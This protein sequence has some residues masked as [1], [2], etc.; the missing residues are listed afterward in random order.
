MYE[1]WPFFRTVVDNAQLELVRANL[2][3]AADY[4]ARVKPSRV[5]KRIHAIIT[6]EYE[7]TVDWVLKTTGQSELMEQS[8]VRKTVSLR[9]PATEPLNKL[10]VALMDLWDDLDGKDVEG[11]SAWH[12]ALLL[13]IAGLAAAMQSTG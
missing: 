1:K 2:E 12:D 11:K 8:V 4:A 9:N 3:T 5:G 7:I 13:S 6:D 10:Q